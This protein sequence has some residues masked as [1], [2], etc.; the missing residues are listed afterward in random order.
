MLGDI[1]DAEA[2]Q[3]LYLMSENVRKNYL[4]RAPVESELFPVTH[5]IHVA[6]YIVYDQSYQYNILKEVA[7]VLPPEE[8][9]KRCKTFCV[10]FNQLG[11]NSVT[12]LYLHGRAQVIYDNLK[13]KKKD[14]SIEVEPEEK[15]KET[16]FVLDYWKRL[17]PNYRNDGELNVTDGNIRILPQ[18]VTDTLRQEMVPVQDNYELKRKFKRT[19][20]KNS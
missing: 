5:Y 19:I 4:G 8:L 13:K 7:K 20:A 12:M 17:S 18:D 1:S 11:M 6:T 2:N 9:A 16:K 15:K 10:P 3:L 14:P